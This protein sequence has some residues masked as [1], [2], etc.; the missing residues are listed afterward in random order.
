MHHNVE[1]TDCNASLAKQE[2]AHQSDHV[3]EL[4]H[5]AVAIHILNVVS[6]QDAAGFGEMEVVLFHSTI[7]HIEIRDIQAALSGTVGREA[8]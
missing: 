7:S 3:T 5:V 2:L 1:K 6:I 4:A 8:F